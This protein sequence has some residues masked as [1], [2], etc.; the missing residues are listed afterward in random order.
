MVQKGFGIYLADT[1]KRLLSENE[2]KN[3]DAVN[4]TFELN[5][6]GI[7]KWNSYQTYED[8]PKLAESLFNKDFIIRIEGQEICRGKFWSGLSSSSYNGII[9]T[10]ALF[11]LN[12]NHN[13]IQVRADYP[14]TNTP[15]NPEINRAL[16]AYFKSLNLLK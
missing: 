8:I 4:Y 1:G 9:I 6:G 16:T 7:Q 10:E 2:I 5:E 12:E 13:T 15:A 11:K 3:Y 14:G